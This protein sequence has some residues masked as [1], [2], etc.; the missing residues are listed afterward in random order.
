[1]VSYMTLK[2]YYKSLRNFMQEQD[3]SEDITIRQKKKECR[4]IPNELIPVIAFSLASK[5]CIHNR[6]DQLYRERK[7][8]IEREFESDDFQYIDVPE[9]EMSL[10]SKSRLYYKELILLCLIARKWLTPEIIKLI[11]RAYPETW[12]E[13]RDQE[14]L[15]LRLL[16]GGYDIRNA[17]ITYITFYLTGITLTQPSI[18]SAQ[19]GYKRFLAISSISMPLPFWHS[20]DPAIVKKHETGIIVRSIIDERY[21]P[22]ECIV[23][24]NASDFLERLLDESEQMAKPNYVLCTERPSINDFIN[25]QKTISQKTKADIKK[26]ARLPSVKKSITYTRNEHSIVLDFL[27]RFLS[28]LF[29]SREEIF[30]VEIPDVVIDWIT[31][32]YNGFD[33]VE[34]VDNTPDEY[35]A[36]GGVLYALV[37]RIY[38]TERSVEILTEAFYEQDPVPKKIDTKSEMDRK[39][40][41]LKQELAEVKAKNKELSQKIN[42]EKTDYE[43]ILNKKEKENTRLREDYKEIEEKFNQLL[44]MQETLIRPEERRVDLEVMK[45]EIRKHNLIF[46]GGHQT[47]QNAMKAEFPNYHFIEYAS[48]NTIVA[49]NFKN[50]EYIVYNVKWN[51]HSMF[52][53]CQKLKSNDSRFIFIDTTNVER[54]IQRIYEMIQRKG[55]KD[56]V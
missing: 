36:L 44:S 26:I 40:E 29:I 24:E 15:W 50:I 34:W 31:Q 13:E 16:V 12:V 4:E 46:V 55:V 49:R 43:K 22:Q 25:D 52:Y 6:I 14:L 7:K 54:T 1:M 27:H 21:Q 51:E 28:N 42:D 37:N 18:L 53:K 45:T 10:S 56:A 48:Y 47:W 23:Y 39:I 19:E 30:D 41:E 3:L 2:E 20:V 38:N 5:K 32:A 17:G 8:E 9:L 33:S 11:K 35:I